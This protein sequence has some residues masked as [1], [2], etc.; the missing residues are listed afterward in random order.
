[1]RLKKLYLNR[2][3]WGKNTG[4]MEGEIEIED[5]SG[6]MKIFLSPERCDAVVALVADQIVEQTKAVAEAM[7]SNILTGVAQLTSDKHD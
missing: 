4:L 5:P 3:Q 6:E 7:K 1:M 2:Q